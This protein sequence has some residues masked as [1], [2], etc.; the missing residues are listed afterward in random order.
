MVGSISHSFGQCVK[1][2]VD[3][4]FPNLAYADVLDSVDRFD[5]NDRS[6]LVGVYNEP[7]GNEPCDPFDDS[8]V[9]VDAFE[10]GDWESLLL[11]NLADIQRTRELAILGGAYVP[12]SDFQMKNLHPPNP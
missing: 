2:E 5:T 8:E 4:P 3:W 10:S 11:H 7:L 12:Q 9:A 1:H 6:D